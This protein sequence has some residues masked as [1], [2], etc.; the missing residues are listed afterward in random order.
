MDKSITLSHHGMFFP[1]FTAK[2]GHEYLLSEKHWPGGW[3]PIL[4][5]MTAK[6]QIYPPK[7]KKRWKVEIKENKR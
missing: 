2:A 3:T 6:K 1:S 5:D 7:E 4:T